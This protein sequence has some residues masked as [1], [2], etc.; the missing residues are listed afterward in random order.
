MKLINPAP[1]RKIT[2]PYGPRKH[3]ITGEIN[4]MHHGIDFGG[5]FDVLAAGDGIIHHVGFSAKGGGNVV[6]I[7]HASKLYSVYYH[8]AHAS[9][10]KVGDRILAGQVVY[11]SG[12]TGDSTGPHLH[13]EI[14]RSPKWGDTVDPNVYISNDTPSQPNSV[15][16]N[17]IN[18]IIL[19]VNG[20]LDKKTWAA[21]QDTLKDHFGYTG[22]I[23]GNP[24]K[25]T[26]SAI[27]RSCVDY[28]YKANLV[29]GIPGVNTRKAV[30]RRLKAT[31]D[32]SGPIDGAW[33]PGT[34]SALQRVLNKGAYK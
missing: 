17:N 31:G 7:Q 21:W 9:K 5:T 19:D 6:I 26:W 29:D 33:G 12:S 20:K 10:F 18:K 11:K 8:G 13:F 24:G 15:G 32:Y 14:R 27:Q 34:I 30:Q 4:R 3:P 1:G 2:S 28:G 16:T 23:D 22:I 25:M